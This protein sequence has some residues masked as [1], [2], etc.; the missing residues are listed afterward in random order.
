MMLSALLLSCVVAVAFA[1]DPTTV[2]G[3]RLG[4]AAVPGTT[5][6]AVGLGTSEFVIVQFMSY[7]CIG[8]GGYGSGFAQQWSYLATKNWLESGGRRIDT[9]LTY[10]DQV[11]I[12]KVGLH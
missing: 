7:V 1:V 3:I 6:P 9:A 8:T 12:S 5:M 4:N 11:N 2:P 10:Y